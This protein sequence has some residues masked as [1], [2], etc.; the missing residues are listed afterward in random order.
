MSGQDIRD[1]VGLLAV[2]AGLVFVGWEIRQNNALAR[3]ATRNEI[4]VQIQDL[5]MNLSSSPQLADVVVRRHN[6]EELTAVENTQF[7]VRSTA[8]FRYFENVH[9]QYRQG[10]YEDSEFLAHSRVWRG[11]M[12]NAGYEEVWCS[13]RDTFSPEFREMFEGLLPNGC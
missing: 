1:T 5:Q 13:L 2:V 7:L 12:A 9:Y 3:A 10:L 8:M 6:G 11:F 4:A